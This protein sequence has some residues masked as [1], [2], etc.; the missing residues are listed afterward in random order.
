MGSGHFRVRPLHVTDVE[1]MGSG[2][3]VARCSGTTLYDHCK[4]SGAQHRLLQ[5]LHRV[6]DVLLGDGIEALANQGEGY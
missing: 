6:W 3:R 4:D 2:L 5:A 1:M